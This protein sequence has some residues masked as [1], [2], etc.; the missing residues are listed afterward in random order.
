MP[1]GKYVKAPPRPPWNSV[2]AIDRQYVTTLLIAL[3]R[4]QWDYCTTAGRLG[5]HPLILLIIT[6][7]EVVIEQSTP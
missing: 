6:V 3:A 2:P 4:A 7:G 5:H 1:F